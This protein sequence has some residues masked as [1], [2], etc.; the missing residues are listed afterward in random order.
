[1]SSSC[2]YAY[3]C[4]GEI[5][6]HYLVVVGYEE[7]KSRRS[8][9]YELLVKDPMEEGDEEHKAE[10]VVKQKLGKKAQMCLEVRL[11]RGGKDSYNNFWAY[12]YDRDLVDKKTH[13]CFCDVCR[14]IIEGSRFNCNEDTDY[15][16]CRVCH[17]ERKQDG[18]TF[19]EVTF[20][21]EEGMV[22]LP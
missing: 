15:D 12:M 16:E 9:T 20:A 8:V 21:E 3:L 17:S 14:Q 1:L 5:P 13:F 10:L 22:K 19:K 2:N 11:N 6:T 7:V 4:S 18:K